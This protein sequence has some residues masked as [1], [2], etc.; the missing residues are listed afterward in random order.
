[1]FRYY[2]KLLSVPLT[3]LLLYISLAAVW[4]VFDF[5]ETQELLVVVNYWFDKYG[6]PALFICSVLE[7]ILLVGTYF[8]GVFVIFVSV[9]LADNPIEAI[10]AI[11]VGT[12]GLMIAHIINYILGKYGWYR[13]F[14]KFGLQNA[15]G[16]SQTKLLKRG[17][18][19]ILGS[20]WSPALGALTDTAAGIMQM[21]FKIFITYSLMSAVLWNSFVGSIVYVWGDGALSIASP[22]GQR[23]FLLYA[24]IGFWITA[25][26]VGDFIEKRKNRQGAVL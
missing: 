15:I 24:I 21:P 2:A 23:N 4:L 22:G 14:V 19:A 20:Y 17:P 11:L 3:F 25:L 7:G 9:I 12:A 10:F 18:I 13:L 8:P 26:L 5:P 1:M 16:Q 6:L